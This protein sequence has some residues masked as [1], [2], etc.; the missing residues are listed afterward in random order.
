[1]ALSDKNLGSFPQAGIITLLVLG[2]FLEHVNSRI[3]KGF[4]RTVEKKKGR[5]D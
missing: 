1:M 5:F 4:L 2:V 3:L